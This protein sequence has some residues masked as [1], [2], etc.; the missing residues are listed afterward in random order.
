MKMTMLTGLKITWRLEAYHGN[1]NIILIQ[2]YVYIRANHLAS[3]NTKTSVIWKIEEH[4][5]RNLVA[6]KINTNAEINDKCQKIG[7]SYVCNKIKFKH[8]VANVA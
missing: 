4:E 5:P 3:V 6:V 7:Y 2:I 8:T 1:N